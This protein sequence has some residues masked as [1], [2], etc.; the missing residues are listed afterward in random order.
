MKIGFEICVMLVI[1]PSFVD[2]EEAKGHCRKVDNQRCDIRTSL[3]ASWAVPQGND[4]AK[5]GRYDSLRSGGEACDM[6]K[7]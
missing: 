2:A 6:I 3:K 5:Q 1:R 4:G 7:R